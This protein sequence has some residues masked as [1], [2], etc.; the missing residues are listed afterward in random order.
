MHRA[1]TSLVVI[2]IK[3]KKVDKLSLT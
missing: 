1:V 2:S 3:L